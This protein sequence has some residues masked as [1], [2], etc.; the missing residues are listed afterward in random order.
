M[1]PPQ[2]RRGWEACERSQ[3]FDEDAMSDCYVI[4][5]ETEGEEGERTSEEGGVVEFGGLKIPASRM[6]E[7]FRVK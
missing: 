7:L 3:L 2:E 6:V 1:A 4:P 5:S